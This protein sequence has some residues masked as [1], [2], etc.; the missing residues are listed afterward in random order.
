M[1]VR[2]TITKIVLEVDE[3]YGTSFY[4]KIYHRLPKL[5]AQP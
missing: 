3:T 4:A 5:N 1:N 2:A